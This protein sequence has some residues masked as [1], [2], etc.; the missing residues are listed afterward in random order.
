MV[1]LKENKARLLEVKAQNASGRRRAGVLGWHTRGR[2]CP[3]PE[4]RDLREGYA[5]PPAFGRKD[6]VEQKEP[7]DR[8]SPPQ[9]PSL[10]CPFRAA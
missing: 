9:L 6:Q 2:P 4:L 3:Q 8:P 1:A 5:S 10:A 7:G